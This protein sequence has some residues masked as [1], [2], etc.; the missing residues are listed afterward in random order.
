M[1][2]HIQSLIGHCTWSNR[3]T[4]ESLLACK[5]A[6]IEGPRLLAHVLAVE[7]IWLSRLQNQERAFINWPSITMNECRAL[8]A[9]CAEG[10][11]VF[12]RGLTEPDLQRGIEFR[13]KQGELFEM[14]VAE[15]LMQVITHG[16]HHRGQIARIVAM[17]G[18]KAASTDF[19]LYARSRSTDD[20]DPTT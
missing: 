7:Q 1:I 16:A 19:I 4:I 2:Q 20:P 13:T 10:W 12:F 18:G 15:I 5:A 14:T 8:A 17:E 6:Q 11:I 9:E 3:L